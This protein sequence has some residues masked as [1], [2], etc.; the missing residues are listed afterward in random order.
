MNIF[1]ISL[2]VIAFLSIA[3][4]LYRGLVAECLTLTSWIIACVFAYYYSDQFTFFL[5][6]YIQSA[7]LRLIIVSILMIVVLLM[8]T[9]TIG[10]CLQMLLRAM[11]LKAVDHILGIGFG[12][13]RAWVMLLVITSG[14]VF[15]HLDQ[16][17]W[18][19]Q[20]QAVPQIQK[21][22][23]FVVK[24]MPSD[25]SFV[26]QYFAEKKPAKETS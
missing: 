12:A 21:S 17:L 11:G 8:F 1:D 2:A 10:Y 14:L 24:W 3:V 20:S 6:P 5:V 22:K 18:F 15:F 7:S 19:K 16:D 4:G 13:A 9:K 25:W 23:Q 26:R